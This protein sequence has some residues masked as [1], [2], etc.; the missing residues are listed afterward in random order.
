MNVLLDR[1]IVFVLLSGNEVL[2]IQIKVNGNFEEDLEKQAKNKEDVKN[3]IV[4]KD[5]VLYLRDL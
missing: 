2:I 5:I 4:H 3:V 1:I